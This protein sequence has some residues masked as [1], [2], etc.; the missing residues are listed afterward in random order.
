[1][2]FVGDGEFEAVDDLGHAR[3]L[4]GGPVHEHGL[5][6]RRDL[7]G[8]SDDAVVE[9][10]L[11]VSPLRLGRRSSE[12][13][14]RRSTLE[15]SAPEALAAG[16]GTRGKTDGAGEMAAGA[17][18]VGPRN[19]RHAGPEAA[20]VDQAAGA[21]RSSSLVDRVTPGTLRAAS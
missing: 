7:T 13:T 18:A 4:L 19:V 14:T 9:R 6:G 5:V 20:G 3:R 2:V 8:Q 21:L 11:T 17:A 12:A 16:L 10:T 15:S 1:M